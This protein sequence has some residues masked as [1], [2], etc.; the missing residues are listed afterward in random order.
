[1]EPST[2]TAEVGAPEAPRLYV[3]SDLHL[4][5][6]LDARTRRYARLEGF[7]YDEEF[8]AFLDA[9]LAD[10]G[11][12]PAHLIL[13][14]DVFDFL[15]V[16]RVPGTAE[17]RAEGLEVTR[18]EQKYGLLPTER[19]ARWKLARIVR[20]HRRFFLALLRWMAS[21][22]DLVLIRGNHDMELFW[23]GVRER[24]TEL[25]IE[26]AVE[27]D[28]ALTRDQIEA[29]LVHRDWFYYE[30]GRVFVE[31][32]H[33]YEVSN[34]VPNLLNP[35]FPRNPFGERDAILDYPAGS[36]FLQ[37]V[38]NRLRLIDPIRT[39]IITGD[40]FGRLLTRSRLFDFVLALGRNFPYLTRLLKDVQP[41]ER[42]EMRRIRRRHA[43][44]VGALADESG[45]GSALLEIDRAKARQAE[46]TTYSVGAT[47][48]RPV[49]WKLFLGIVAVLFGVGA[50]MGIHTWLA[51]SGKGGEAWRVLAS[52]AVGV[53][54]FLAV[55]VAILTL[56]RQ[57]RDEG[58][59]LIDEHRRA[60]ERV[61]RL[62]KVPIVVMGHTHV[63]DYY[64]APRTGMTAINSGTWTYVDAPENTIRPQA[65][66]FTFVR[67]VGR[68]AELLRW[69]DARARFEPPPL[70][71]L[72]PP[73]VRD[74][75]R[76]PLS[77][78]GR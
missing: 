8:A 53:A 66:S 2:T 7:F 6:G 32:G 12:H 57:Q 43:E 22:R 45:L 5:E 19:K 60:C 30:P 55:F 15:A 46:T 72:G 36:H 59:E 35:V 16:V 26:I 63:A 40:Q 50:Y 10:A 62:A 4:A 18:F 73:R 11:D 31:H 58:E 56:S 41:F 61:A 44:R 13:N 38:F 47:L 75:L 24:L 17:R 64:R 76:A 51:L 68:D 14:G 67:I 1:M 74:R 25:L 54:T 29:R 52:G 48:V 42:G 34:C 23:P 28:V 70:I 78:T 3:A 9:C 37:I 20:G 39:H 65:R 27:E 21:G 69:H 71:A 49:L 77:R 33:Q